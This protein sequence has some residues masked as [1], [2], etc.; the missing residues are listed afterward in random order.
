MS[1]LEHIPKQYHDIPYKDIIDNATPVNAIAERT[2]NML[3]HQRLIHCGDFNFKDLHK[4]IDG[5]PDL[6]SFKLDD[7]TQ[8][9]TCLKSKLTKVSPGARSLREMATRPYQLLYLDY[10]FSGRISRDKDGNVI[11]SSQKDI[12]GIN[13][14]TSWLLISDGKTRMLHGDCRLSKVSPI[15]YLESFLQQYAPACKNKWAVMDQG[16][17][18]YQSTAVRSLFKKYGY[19]IL[20]TKLHHRFFCPVERK[21]ISR[22]CVFLDVASGFDP[23]D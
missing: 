18:L 9:A 4:H 14:E 2:R 15:K 13:G 19:E 6:S 8:C 11:E 5:I 17:E 1:N 21:I 16:G 20:P 10:G 12:E 23:Q 22:I 3:W 7:V